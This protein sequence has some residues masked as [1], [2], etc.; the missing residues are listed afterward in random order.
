VV[1]AFLPVRLVGG[2]RVVAEA[3][4]DLHLIGLE[5]RLN[6]EGTSGSTLAG[7]AVAD[8]D[9]ERIALDFGTKLPAGTGCIPGG[10]HGET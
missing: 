2:T 9:S 4:D 10:H 1:G 6:P 5:P 3:A 8:R 7:T